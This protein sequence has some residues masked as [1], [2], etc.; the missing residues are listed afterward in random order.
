MKALSIKQAWLYAITDLDKRIEN[1]TWYPPHDIIGQRIALHA[2][3]RDEPGS[4]DFVQ[5]ISGVRVPADLPRGCLV[6]TARVVGWIDARGRSY[7]LTTVP[8]NGLVHNKWFAGPV[9]WLLDDIIKIDPV[10]ARGMLGLW[11]C[12]L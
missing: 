2:S 9:G 11:E 5:R 7:G 1:R 12:A 8:E 6:A 3:K 4:A 10:P